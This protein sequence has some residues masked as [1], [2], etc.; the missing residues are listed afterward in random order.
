MASYSLMLYFYSLS[1]VQAHSSAFWHRPSNDTT[2]HVSSNV[3]GVYV[4]PGVLAHSRYPH[5]ELSRTKVKGN[6]CNNWSLWEVFLACLLASVI[7]TAI[8]VLI[9]CLV[10]NRGNDNSPIT[11]LL[12][13]NNDIPGMTSTTSKPAVTT[14]STEPTTITTST[15]STTTATST[16]PT[17]PAGP[18]VTSTGPTTLTAT[19]VTTTGPTTSTSAT[20]TSTGL[21]DT[22]VTTTGPITTAKNI[23]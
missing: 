11:S 9:I 12:P 23:P 7:T 17:T 14:T 16:E 22:T 15:E 10:N 8:G 2:G 19:T 13:S 1:H 21:T 20:I 3:T 4:S 6:C 18:T 5:T